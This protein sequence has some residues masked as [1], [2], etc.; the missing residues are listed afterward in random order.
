MISYFYRETILLL[1]VVI[2][3]VA[4]L[5]YLLY[6]YVSSVLR[7]SK[8][9]AASSPSTELGES[10]LCQMR[11]STI[12]VLIVTIFFFYDTG[13]VFFIIVIAVVLVIIVIVVFFF[14][15]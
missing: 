7:L 3:L 2:K 9:Q 13:V 1:S 4:C 8:M 14:L 12:L 10:A 11:C 15:Q 6:V 5:L